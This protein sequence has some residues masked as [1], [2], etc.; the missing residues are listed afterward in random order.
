MPSPFAAK[1]SLSSNQRQILEHLSG[2]T[3]NPYRLVRRCKIIL[4]AADGYTNSA[5]A[6]QLELNRPQ[7]SSWRHRWVEAMEQLQSMEADGISELALRQSIITLLSDRLRPG[8]PAKFSVDQMVSIV[9]LA[10]EL[11]ASSQRPISHWTPRELADE[12]VNRGI[13]E[14]ISTRSVGRFLKASGFAT[15][16]QPLLAQCQSH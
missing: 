5:I 7:V 10:C 11:P 3:T 8:A 1:L 13:V 12:A 6:R 16:S 15:A 2:Q 9:A 14:K 4:M